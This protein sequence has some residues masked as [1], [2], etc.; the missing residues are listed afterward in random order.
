MSMANASRVYDGVVLSK[1]RDE[2]CGKK[3]SVMAMRDS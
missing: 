2:N 3:G 1:F